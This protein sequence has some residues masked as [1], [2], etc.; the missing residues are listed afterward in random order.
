[1]REY[2]SGNGTVRKWRGKWQGIIRYRDVETDD[3]GNVSKSPWK[4]KS[5]LFD[6][7]SYPNSNRGQKTAETELRK[8][9]SQLI[10]EEPERAKREQEERDAAEARERGVILITPQSTLAEWLDCYLDDLPKGK[11]IEKSTMRGYGHRRARI[12]GVLGDVRLCRLTRSNVVQLRDALLD[13]GLSPVSANDVLAFLKSALNEAVK[14]E[15]VGRNVASDVR[16][17]VE[18][19]EPN[20]LDDAARAALLADL[21]AT[22]SATQENRELLGQ[23]TAQALG[24]KLALLTGM[25]QGEIC[26]LRWRDVDLDKRTITVRNSIGYDK[27]GALY[28]KRPKSDSGVRCIPIDERLAL[29]LSARREQVQSQLAEVGARLSAKAYVIGN[30][31]GTPTHPNYLY[32][33]FKRRVTRLGLVGTEGKAP[34]FHDLRHTFATVMAHSGV[35]ANSLKQIMGHSSITTTYAYYI[36]VDDD[37][38]RR[39]MELT[40]QR[41]YATPASVVEF[42]RTGTEG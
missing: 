40:A 41:M 16:A 29:D 38:N 2:A 42:P 27:N 36:G 3:D 9:K 39:A 31:D 18:R 24:I 6:I 7:K 19:T 28:E 22:L 25:R 34:S 35:P 8:W 14:R 33:A 1:M 37:A 15:L 23:S 5:R 4:M 32:H 10:A 20:Y 13:D 12:V 11:H 21:D 17:A 26:G 30:A